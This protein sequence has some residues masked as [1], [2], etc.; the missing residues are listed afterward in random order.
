LAEELFIFM[1]R[2]PFFSDI[3]AELFVLLFLHPQGRKITGMVKKE[4]LL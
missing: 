4:E 2:F 1:M 3:I